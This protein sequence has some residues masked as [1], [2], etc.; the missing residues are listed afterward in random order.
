MR[1]DVHCLQSIE[2]GFRFAPQG[3]NTN[4]LKNDEIHLP[5]LK[6]RIYPLC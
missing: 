6:Q 3:V 5:L 1:E 4:R 2:M